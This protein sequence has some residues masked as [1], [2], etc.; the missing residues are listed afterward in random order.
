[1]AFR[2]RYHLQDRED[3]RYYVWYQFQYILFLSLSSS[4]DGS[5]ASQQSEEPRSPALMAQAVKI[6]EGMCNVMYFA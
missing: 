4:G 3:R 5:S 1:M 6:H 2:A